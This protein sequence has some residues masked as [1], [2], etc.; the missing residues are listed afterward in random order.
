[1]GEAGARGPEVPTAAEG[2][3]RDTASGCQHEAKR[4]DGFQIALPCLALPDPSGRA[5]MRGIFPEARFGRYAT[6]VP[7]GEPRTLGAT[8]MGVAETMQWV[9]EKMGKGQDSRVRCFRICECSLVAL[10]F[11][12][13]YVCEIFTVACIHWKY[14]QAHV[15]RRKKIHGKKPSIP[16]KK[17][18]TTLP[19]LEKPAVAR[20]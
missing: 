7:A 11:C 4:R 16:K 15:M 6:K 13:R 12:V 3:S 8:Y 9:C 20:R 18:S 14:L 19:G 17:K 5:I 2:D 1:M 10:Q